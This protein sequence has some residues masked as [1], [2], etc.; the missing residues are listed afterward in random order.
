MRIFRG[1]ARG[2]RGS[3]ESHQMS[4]GLFALTTF[5]LTLVFCNSPSFPFS[6][7]LKMASLFR[8]VR[9]LPLTRLAAAARP[10]QTPAAG[11]RAFSTSFARLAGQGPPQLLGE[12]AKAGTIPTE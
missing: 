11:V 6:G 4:I 5:T 2:G 9:A 8:S 1:K 3:G 12:G 10:V 7:L